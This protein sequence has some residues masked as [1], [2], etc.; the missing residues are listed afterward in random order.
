MQKRII[1]LCVA[2]C[3][4]TSLFSQS[5]NGK[6]GYGVSPV[7]HPT[8]YSQF[9]TFLLEVANTCN[10]GAVM[11]NGS[12]RDN[13]ANS[14]NIPT[15]QKTIA[16]LQ[17]VPYN[18][19]DILV[20]GWATY[21]TL[22]LNT[23]NDSTN[24][25]T[26]S[27]MRNLF[28]KTLVHAA[29]SLNPAYIFIGNEVNFYFAQDSSDYANWA[30]FY[31]MAYDSIKFYSPTTKVGTIFNYEHLSGQGI[32]TGWNTPL[33]NALLDLDTSKMDIVGLTLY[34]FFNAQQANSVSLNYLDAL[35]S[36]I[37]NIPLAITETGWPGD[38]LYGN[39]NASPQEQVDWV[40][41]LFNILNG[42]NVEVVN[43]LFL[44]YMMDNSNTPESLIF[45]S[46]AMRDSI[47]NDRPAFSVWQSYCP[48]T[49][50]NENTYTEEQV[51]I[52]PNPAANNF[53]LQ[54]DNFKNEQCDLKISDL[55]GR[56][57]KQ[58]QITDPKTEITIA[59]LP[60]GIYFYQLKNN[61]GKLIIQQKK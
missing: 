18:Y 25:W 51:K 29:D 47:G 22:Y 1:T 57:V 23:N 39:W 38:S 10:G 46:I 52:Y 24:N 31:S 45:K 15:L 2:L 7:G 30:S 56:E 26:N 16:Q 35:F 13:I 53:T 14:G 32:N 17:P 59:N 12:W 44:N 41:K 58:I 5:F 11:A 49:S 37:G 8:D 34:P 3:L 9:G 20:F 50:L 21:P 4:T 61:T 42:R 55:L 54:I 33:W 28:I 60:D 27:T 6:L 36:K 40:N 43:W 19:T 48:A